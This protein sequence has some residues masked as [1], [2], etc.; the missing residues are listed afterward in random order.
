MRIIL[1]ALILTVLYTGAAFAQNVY[2]ANQ[3]SNT[4]SVISDNPT[5]TVDVG[6]GPSALAVTPDGEFVYVANSASA[7]VSVIQTSNNTVVDTVDVGTSPFGV[8]VTPN[9]DFVYVANDF[10]NNVSVIQ[11]SSNTVIATVAVG[12]SPTGVA[13]PNDTYVFVANAASNT[14]SVIQTSNNNVV[15]TV[16][17]GEAPIGIAAGPN[18]DFV[19]VANSSSNNVSVLPVGEAIANPAGPWVTV[20]VGTGPTGIATSTN[21]TINLDLI[22]VTNQDSNTITI[23]NHPFSEIEATLDVADSPTGI[24]A[25]ANGDLIYV[26]HINSAMAGVIEFDTTVSNGWSAESL[27][28]TG[29]EPTSVAIAPS[30]GIGD[31]DPPMGQSSADNNSCALAAPGASPTFPLYLLIPAFILVRRLFRKS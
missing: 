13:I 4:V 24:A 21:S 14:V 15:A 8:A 7:S 26:T 11:T 2:I 31:P 27:F 10:S 30:E 28:P 16:D 6:M 19:Y 29:N 9:G 25:T 12:D 3:T 17:V 23:I 1:A 22:Y 18:G 20:A 5:V